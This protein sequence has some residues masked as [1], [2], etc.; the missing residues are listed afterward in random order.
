MQDAIF[1]WLQSLRKWFHPNCGKAPSPQWKP[2]NI[3]RNDFESNLFCN[4]G[5]NNKC[6]LKDNV[7]H[8]AGLLNTSLVVSPLPLTMSR[9][10]C[11]RQNPI[12]FLTPS[13]ALVLASSLTLSPTTSLDTPHFLTMWDCPSLRKPSTFRSLYI[14]N[15]FCGCTTNV[16]KSHY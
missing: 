1:I 6:S 3:K 4:M 5:R 7:L 13:P 9:V 12:P 14:K 11:H 10:P 2:T 15:S 16:T 8:G